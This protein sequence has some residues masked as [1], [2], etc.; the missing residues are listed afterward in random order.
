MRVHHTTFTE[1]S[2]EA[3]ICA[4]VRGV[5]DIPVLRV[6]GLTK[7]FVGN[8]VLRDADL[9]VHRGQVVGLVGE[10]GAG[11]STL[12]KVL[13]GVHQ[14]DSGEI[15]LEGRSVRFTH[16]LQAQQA[17]ISTVFQEFN[18]LPERTIAENIHL[19]REP[20]RR[21]IVDTAAMVRRAGRAGGR[22]RARAEP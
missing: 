3:V 10:N 7:S 11:K 14:A 17:G 20:S 1:F 6:R 8:T 13:A 21:G 12:M 16:P 15:E 4:T 22:H 2:T 19:G 18:L 9:D 5:E